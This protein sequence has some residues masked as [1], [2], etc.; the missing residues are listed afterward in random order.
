MQWLDHFGRELTCSPDN[1]WPKFKIIIT[2]Q[3]A[4]GLYQWPVFTDIPQNLFILACSIHV[5]NR[6]F[7]PGFS[8]NCC[9]YY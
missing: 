3:K 6:S 7:Y 8:E 1:T 9:S 5:Y 2:D 4:T